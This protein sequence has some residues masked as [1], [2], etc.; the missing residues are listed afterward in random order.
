MHGLLLAMLLF[1]VLAATLGGLLRNSFAPGVSSSAYF[2]V[3]AAAA[4]MGIVAILSAL[5]ALGRL[6]VWLQR[7][8][9][10]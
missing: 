4:P 10:K 3:M 7:R 2:I 1:C 8:R 9:K 6:V 5:Q